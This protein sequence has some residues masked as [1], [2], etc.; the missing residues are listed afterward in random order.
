MP[1][2]PIFYSYRKKRYRASIPIEKSHPRGGWL[3]ESVIHILAA[4]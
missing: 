1:S 4:R 2:S 3:L